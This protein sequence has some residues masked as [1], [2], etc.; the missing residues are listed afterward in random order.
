[1]DVCYIHPTAFA[2][3]LGV[4][5]GVCSHAVWLINQ[6]KTAAENGKLLTKAKTR[7]KQR[8]SI[9]ALSLILGA[10]GGFL[11]SLFAG[12]WSPAVLASLAFGA[13]YA[14]E[15]FADRLGGKTRSLI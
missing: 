1:M 5:G 4:L 11:V 9:L 10:V 15:R 6:T 2:M 8:L 12:S 3:L 7:V 13:G 14:F